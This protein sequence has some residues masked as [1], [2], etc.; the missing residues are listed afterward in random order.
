MS[1]PALSETATETAAP[2]PPTPLDERL[3]EVALA[4]LAEEGLEG[5]TLR[6]IARRAGVSHAAPARHF[7]SLADLRA[8]VAARGFA[9]LSQAMERADATFPEDAGVMERLS[10][11]ARAYLD[12][13]VS[14]P[15]LFALMFRPELLD[16]ENASLRRE[17]DAAFGG[18]LRHVRAAQDAGWNTGR[19]TRLL[20]GSMWAAVHGLA[21]L[22]S[23]G[24]Y[25]GPIP[26]ASL[27]DALAT[28][29]EL[30]APGRHGGTR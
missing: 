10:A 23:Q 6:Q 24:A 17:A 18:L 16:F 12:C 27:E 28:T 30:V 26:G 25:Q 13:A 8:E 11:A 19:D 5:L 7:R 14:H 3:V 20:A 29:L 15:A 9:L 22:W 1:Q 4:L 21:S 2:A